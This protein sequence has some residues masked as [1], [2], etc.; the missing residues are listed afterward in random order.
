MT[1]AKPLARL[2]HYTRPCASTS[3]R[4]RAWRGAAEARA[5]EDDARL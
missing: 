4:D 5:D 3:S 1:S 2:L